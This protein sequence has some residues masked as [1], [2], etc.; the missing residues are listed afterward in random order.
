M[1]CRL[2]R[3]R[4]WAIRCVHEAEMAEAPNGEPRSFFLTLTYDD[5][6][7]PED[8]SVNVED[9]QLFAKRYRKQ[10]GS[11]R[12]LQC[13]EYGERTLRPH[14]HALVF[15]TELED[16]RPH[17]VEKGGHQ[18]YVSEELEDL[19]QNGQCLIGNV[20]FDSAAYVARYCTKKAGGEL[21]KSRYARMDDATGSVHHVRPEFATMS[22]RP[23]LGFTWYQR[24]KHQ[25]YPEDQVTIAG[26]RMR[27]PRYYDE[28]L[29]V[30][31]PD[32]FSEVMKKRRNEAEKR[33]DLTR[34]DREQN[35][36]T[37]AIT[38]AR[39]GLRSEKL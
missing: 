31:D 21:A 11:F 39:M 30:E 18:T 10:K 28:L 22:R 33:V 34:S 36:A 23:G 19:W 5:E 9:W 38:K 16:R 15:D 26:R 6:H 29:S 7:L 24:W 14:H 13:A 27:P 20:S 35:R 8:R 3:S 17:R 2:E 25:V 4:H 12:Y 32:L 37:E 1:G